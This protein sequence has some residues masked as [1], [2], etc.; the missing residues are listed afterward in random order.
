M[1]V[2]EQAFTAIR[3]VFKRHG[4]VE[5][6][7]PVFELKEVCVYTD[8]RSAVTIKGLFC[9]ILPDGVYLQLGPSSTNVSQGS[10]SDVS[11]QSCEHSPLSIAAVLGTIIEFG[12]WRGLLSLGLLCISLLRTPARH[13]MESRSPMFVLAALTDAYREV[14]RGL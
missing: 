13:T 7:T 12:T 4:A 1:R 3:N 6:D 9:A 5:I 8:G 11:I 14:R 2:R 10:G